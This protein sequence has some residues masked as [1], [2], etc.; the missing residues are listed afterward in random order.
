MER[1]EYMKIQYKYFPESIR[2]AYQLCNLVT[3]QGWI[4]IKITKGMYGLKQAARIAYD[5]LKTRLAKHGYTPCTDNVNFW[6]HTTRRTKFSLCVDDFRIKYFT[7]QDAQHL[8]HALATTY[9]ITTDPTGTN[10]L[11]LT[12]KWNY[13]D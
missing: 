6:Q 1:A 12:I 10:Y 7:P 8:L 13:T 9:K 4:Y 3:P 2:Q 11:G 5:L